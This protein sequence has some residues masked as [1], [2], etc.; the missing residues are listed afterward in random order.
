[1]LR[2]QVARALNNRGTALRELGRPQDALAAYQQVVD[3]YGDD[4]SPVLRERVARALNNRGVVLGEL[5]RPQEAL[6]AYQ[7]VIDDYRDDPSLREEV[8]L[9][10]AA[11][12]ELRSA[13]TTSEGDDVS[14]DLHDRGRRN[15]N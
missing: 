9:A 15:P 13:P 6:A 11:C 8:E 3:D 1:V 7:Q 5:G 12:D 2:E 14:G 10:T 4:P